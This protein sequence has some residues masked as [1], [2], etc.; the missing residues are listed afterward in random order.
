MAHI[1]KLT[2]KPRKLP[3]RAQVRR[4]G[5]G[6]RVKCFATKT[7]AE[8]WAAEQERRRSQD[9]PLGRARKAVDQVDPTRFPNIAAVREELFSGG[10]ARASWAIQV[11]LLRNPPDFSRINLTAAAPQSFP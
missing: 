8:H 11:L 7:E 2:D 5:H 6:V 1:Q 9:D 4:K 10:A 3:W